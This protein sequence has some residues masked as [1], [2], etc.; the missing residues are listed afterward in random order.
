M[1]TVRCLVHLNKNHS[2]PKSGVTPAEFLILRA[3]HSKKTGAPAITDIT[4]DTKVEVSDAEEVERLKARYPRK[5]QQAV[6]ERFYDGMQP[7]LPQT[8]AEIG[9]K[10]AGLPETAVEVPKTLKPEKKG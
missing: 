2:V 4:A 10:V 7:K 6:L 3:C 8:F 5:E 1:N 9:V